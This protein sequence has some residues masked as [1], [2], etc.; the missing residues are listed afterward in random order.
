MINLTIRSEDYQTVE[1]GCEL[2]LGGYH[3]EKTYQTLYQVNLVLSVN[4]VN[5][6]VNHSDIVTIAI[7]HNYDT[8]TFPIIRI[9]LQSDLALLQNILEYPDAIEIVGDLNGNVYLLENDQSKPTLVSG[10]HNISFKM[11]GY[12]EHKNMPTSIMDQYRDGKRITTDLNQQSKVPIELYGYNQ[13]L[14]YY[15]KRL[16]QSIYK[17]MGMTSII[18]D[19][20]SRGNIT[21][22][23]MD[24]LDQQTRF[25][26]VLIPNLNLLQALVYFDAYYGLY[27]K[28][29]HIYGDLDQLYMSN[30]SSEV[31]GNIIPIQVMSS[32]NESDMVGLKKYNDNTYQMSVMFNNVSVLSES[33][34]ERLMAAENIGAVNVNTNEIQSASLKELYQYKTNEIFGNQDIPH[35]LHKHVNPFIATSNAAR[36]KEKITKIDLSA[37]GFDIGDMHV[38]TR[39]N[40]LFDSS[41]RGDGI[42]GLYRPSFVNHILSN[43]GNNLLMSQ[44]TMQLCKN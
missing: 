3:M 11:K 1:G 36:I 20:F 8:M 6:Q 43:A 33:D 38:N 18:E 29:C 19:M 12:I 9:R 22:Y 7:I 14:V 35:I 41:I 5:Y 30:A 13:S 28:G 31:Y 40:I 10:A 21:K 15:M 17:D 25:E 26:Q 32:K 44:T 2:Q 34:I 39:Y 23:N 16:T 42:Q 4:G 27:E 37:G 24:P